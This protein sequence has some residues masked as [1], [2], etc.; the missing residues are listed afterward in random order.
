LAAALGG[1]ALDGISLLAR[2]RTRIKAVPA[3]PLRTGPA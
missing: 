1:L 2:S 3:S